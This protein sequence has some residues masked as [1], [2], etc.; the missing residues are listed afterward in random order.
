MKKLIAIDLDGT[1]LNEKS[2]ISEENTESLQRAQ[3]AG[4]E[5]VIATGRAY[6]DVI[7]LLKPTGMHPWVIGANGAT[8]HD[9]TGR[10]LLSI[11]L[12]HKQAIEILHWLEGKHFYYEVFSDEAIFTPQN[13]RE[14]LAIEMDRLVSANPQTDLGTLSQAAAKQFSQTGF[15]Y[16]SSYRDL[17]DTEVNIYNILAF[18]FDDQKLAKGWD[19]FKQT[20]NVTLVTSAEHNFELEHPLASKGNALTWLAKHLHIPLEHTVAIGDS[21]NDYSMITIAGY[22]IAMGNARAEIKQISHEVTLSNYEHGVSHS[23]ER[24]LAAKRLG[25]N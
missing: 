15:S 22:S 20:D 6:F 4:M 8:I 13:G 5:V 23:I 17:L 19:R 16:V 7:D 14:L 11:P 21:M 9:P 10:R 3:E 24:L 18:S 12:E 25:Q 2:T 1:L